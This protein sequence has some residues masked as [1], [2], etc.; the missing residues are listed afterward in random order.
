[1]ALTAAGTQLTRTHWLLQ[2]TLRSQL[3]GGVQRLWPIWTGD[4]ASF[5]QFVQRAVPLVQLG[6]TRSSG[7]A[8]AYY[9]AFRAAEA[10]RVEEIREG[11][12]NGPVAAPPPDPEQVARSMYATGLDAARAA[13]S[14]QLSAEQARKTALT[15][16]NGA[17]T[18][19]ALNGGRETVLASVKADN[20]ATG[21]QRVIVS[22]RPCAFC[23]MYAARGPVYKSASTAGFRAHDH[24]R[25]IAEPV[26]TT[27]DEA[28]SDEARYYREVWERAQA[29]ALA[30]G[31]DRGLN[32]LRRHL[33]REQGISTTSMATDMGEAGRAALAKQLERYGIDPADI[34]DEILGVVRDMD[35]ELRAQSMAWYEEA[36]DFAVELS[37]RYDVPLDQVTGVISAVSPRLQWTQNKHL[38]ERLLAHKDSYRDLDPLEAAKAIGGGLS[39]NTK[40]GVQILRGE[41]IDD[42]LTGMK[43]RSFYNNILLP[44]QTADVTVDMWMMKA[45]EAAGVPENKLN[46]FIQAQK[47]STRGAGAGYVIISDAVRSAAW[48]YGTTPDAMQAAY[49]VAKTGKLA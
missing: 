30:E 32:A 35:P 41:P 14:R 7:L 11:D 42:V 10:T 21:W 39:A 44:G 6:H 17:A 40:V 16:V 19:H 33:A 1:M 3:S 25:C 28:W 18:R 27:G 23:V 15:N 13:L 9:R 34:V 8:S 12:W 37:E 48:Q 26:F 2:M 43:R 20:G 29:E 47:T 4:A 49:W 31:E 36:H 46:S 24:D 45:A 38:A 5:A 22:P